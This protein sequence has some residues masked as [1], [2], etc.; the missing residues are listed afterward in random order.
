MCSGCSID[1]AWNSPQCEQDCLTSCEIELLAGLN[2]VSQSLIA[3]R[4][5]WMCRAKASG[6]ITQD[7][8]QEGFEVYVFCFVVAVG[9]LSGGAISIAPMN[10]SE[11]ILFIIALLIGSVIMAV[12]QGVICGIVTIGDPHYIEHRQNTDQLNFLMDD[13]GVDQ[14][15][16]VRVREYYKCTYRYCGARRT[17]TS[18]PCSHQI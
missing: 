12:V 18:C 10:I 7:W 1:D 5:H 17:P 16:K 3:N 14:D 4:E 15:L 8:D 13:M 2:G 9:Q 11:N 6:Q